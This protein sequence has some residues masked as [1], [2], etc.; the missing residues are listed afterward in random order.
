VTGSQR[1]TQAPQAPMRGGR[2]AFALQSRSVRRLE[3]R[4]A[5]EQRQ[6]GWIPLTAISSQVDPWIDDIPVVTDSRPRGTWLRTTLGAV[7]RR[8][9]RQRRP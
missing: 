6:A 1:P 5:G 4:A 9:G 8:S 7:M 2:D 3:A